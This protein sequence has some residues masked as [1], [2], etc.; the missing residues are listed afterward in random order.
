MNLA[1]SI[2]F[3]LSIDYVL[4]II[5]CCVVSHKPTAG[6]QHLHNSPLFCQ[7]CIPISLARGAGSAN[8]KKKGV[9][10]R[11][12]KFL[13]YMFR[14]VI[15]T[16]ES[17]P[18]A[19]TVDVP[20]SYPRCTHAPL[21]CLPIQT[22]GHSATWEQTNARAIE[23]DECFETMHLAPWVPLT[24]LSCLLGSA[25]VRRKGGKGC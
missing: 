1:C 4:H 10:P 17:I 8:K 9:A 15:N 2:R 12:L 18:C 22:W 11:P 25:C 19:G 23:A 14:L 21:A 7:Y 24:L 16:G 6:T 13:P 3:S 5:E 20:R